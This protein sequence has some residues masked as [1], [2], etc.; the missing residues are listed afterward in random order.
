MKEKRRQSGYHYGVTVTNSQMAFVYEVSPIV[1][2]KHLPKCDKTFNTW[3]EAWEYA[4]TSLCATDDTLFYG[5]KLEGI[6]PTFAASEDRELLESQGFRVEDDWYG[7]LN[8]EGRNLQMKEFEKRS[9]I[10]SLVD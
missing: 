2:M 10:D 1:D 9:I 5:V 3:D 6:L 8:F 7:C 4:E